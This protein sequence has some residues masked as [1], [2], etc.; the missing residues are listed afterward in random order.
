MIDLNKA[1]AFS[2]RLSL[3]LDFDKNIPKYLI[4][5]NIRIHRIILE[6]LTNSLNF[7]DYGFVKL[8]ALLAKQEGREVILKFI[9]EDT[10][11]GIPQDKQQE[12]FLQ[13][14]NSLLLIKVFIQVLVLALQ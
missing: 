11:I 2:K 5:D 7:T 8:T 12:I 13:F 3:S 4:G 1:K 9:V 14:K 10:G 6:L